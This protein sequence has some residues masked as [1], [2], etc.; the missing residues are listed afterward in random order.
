MSTCRPVIACSAYYRQLAEF[1]TRVC[2]FS[3]G[4]LVKLTVSYL[5]LPIICDYPPLLKIGL[6]SILFRICFKMPKLI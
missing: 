5:P 4:L 1:G 6:S 2:R 3:I